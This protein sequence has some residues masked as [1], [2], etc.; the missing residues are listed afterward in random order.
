[1]LARAKKKVGVIAHQHPGVTNGLG[2]RDK[3]FQAI[4]EIVFIRI[5]TRYFAALDTPYDDMVQYTR[6]VYSR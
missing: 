2:F 3:T 5:T 6:R 1:V 4:R